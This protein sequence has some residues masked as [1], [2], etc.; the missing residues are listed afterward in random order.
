[1][2][3]TAVGASELAWLD[4]KMQPEILRVADGMLP[5]AITPQPTNV[6]N[7]SATTW[8]EVLKDGNAG[9]HVSTVFLLLIER[10]PRPSCNQG[11]STQDGK[12]N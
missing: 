8:P 1:M 11:F 6:R 5:L 2:A 9:L 3:A 4:W 10:F 7:C 12:K